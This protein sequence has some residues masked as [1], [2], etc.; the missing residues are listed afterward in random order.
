MGSGLSIDE[1]QT[2]TM[3]AW[4]LWSKLGRDERAIIMEIGRRLFHGQE[5][6]GLFRL[7]E[8]GRDWEKEAFEEGCDWLVY[9]SAN[10]IKRQRGK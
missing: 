3:R 2:E 7:D 8:D 9:Q 6:Y 1:E 5:Q 4:M 10:Y